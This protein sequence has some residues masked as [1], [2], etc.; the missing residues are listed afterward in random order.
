MTSTQRTIVKQTKKP[1]QTKNTPLKAPPLELAGTL[2]FKMGKDPT[3][4]PPAL[5]WHGIQEKNIH[6]VTMKHVLDY[7]KRPAHF[8]LY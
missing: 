6:D 2:R 1:T 5:N 8:L 4:A 7:C 3:E